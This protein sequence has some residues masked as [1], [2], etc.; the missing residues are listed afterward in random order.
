L[1]SNEGWQKLPLKVKNYIKTDGMPQS[2][3]KF[4]PMPGKAATKLDY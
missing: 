3:G 2:T 4:L 1:D